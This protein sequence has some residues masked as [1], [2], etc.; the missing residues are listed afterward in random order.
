[1]TKKEHGLINKVTAGESLWRKEIRKIQEE[2]EVSDEELTGSKN[3]L[4]NKVD[5]KNREKFEEQIKR[6]A[7]RKSKIKH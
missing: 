6:E 1:M 5:K 2:Y 3:R 7:E 4:K